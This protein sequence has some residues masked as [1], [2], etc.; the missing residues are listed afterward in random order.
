MERPI[1]L[2]AIRSDSYEQLQSGPHFK[3][4]PQYLFSLPP[5]AR[6][7][8]KDVI[9]GPAARQ[10]AAGK[11]L[12]VDPELTQQLIEDAEG[13]DA[14]PL[15]AFTLERLLKDY[16][17][18][19]DLL[20]SEY[21]DLGGIEGS[22][23]KAIK[24]AFAN[25]NAEPAIPADGNQRNSLLRRGFLPW[26]ALIDP[27]TDER[28]RRVARWQEI[29]ADAR[30][31][32]ERLIAQRLLIRDRRRLDDGEEAVVVEVAHEA[33][34]R[35]WPLLSRWLDEDADAL[36][37]IH[38][39]KQAATQWSKN[40]RNPEWL[41]HRGE[42]R[43]EVEELLQR[44]DLDRLLGD[45]G[46]GYVRACRQR[47]DFDAAEIEKREREK[48]ESE[49][50]A[51]EAEK[52]RAEEQAEAA[53]GLTRRTG[54]GAVIAVVLM[55]VAGALAWWAIQQ[56]RAAQR[57]L[58]NNYWTNG[59]NAEKGNNPIT[60]AHFFVRATEKYRDK[61]AIESGLLKLRTVQM[62]R[63]LIALDA[64][65]GHDH[66]VRGAAFSKDETRILTW[67]RDKTARLWRAEDG[68]ELS[69]M[70]HDDVVGAAFSKDETRILTW[71]R[72][73]TARLWD[74]GADYDFPLEYLALR[75]EV[76]TGT[77]M[78]RIGNVEFLKPEEWKAK[79]KEYDRIARE[80][81]A[82]CRYPEANRYLKRKR[83]AAARA[84]EG[85]S[86]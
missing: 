17:S 58:A 53:R 20:L 23:D 35:Q 82:T 52:K 74:V 80:H 49:Q 32:I 38:A 27:D 39:A 83:E 51:M 62:N 1:L 13:T 4:I 14:L 55:L 42:R 19:G 81:A 40:D 76:L 31:L 57:S 3:D 28:K 36:K 78:D 15:L 9:E 34:L 26:L 84:L 24:A 45:Q 44:P 69:R 72:N 12:W 79:K 8:Y 60:A 68:A 86:P 6:E 70:G 21:Q 25:P 66:V 85:S 11:K 16:G 65:L 54:V 10:T 7:Q 22:I 56:E 47:D 33:L 59:R 50:R 5:M 37:S 75:V 67:S 18:D 43:R 77:T 46:R 73:N 48:R 2:I 71:S 41:T 61:T 29:P 63:N 30:P 64:I